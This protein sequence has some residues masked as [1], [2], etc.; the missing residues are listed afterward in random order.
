MSTELETQSTALVTQVRSIGKVVDAVTY[1]RK[2]EA[3]VGL[4]TLLKAIKAHYAPMKEAAD[5]AH[6]AVC[7]S[8]N[9]MVNPL[10]ALIDEQ[11]ADL[12]AW[13]RKQDQI[14]REEEL[15]VQT[16]ER[17]RAEDALLAEAAAAEAAGETAIAEAI[18]DLPVEA[19]RVVLPPSVPKVEGLRERPEY[20]SAEVYSLKMLVQAVAEGKVPMQ[21]IQAN[22][23][24]LNAQARSMKSTLAYPGVK[25]VSR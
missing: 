24:F 7:T 12:V 3:I 6:K 9:S 4:K 23:T 21:A 1:T 11:D 15:R 14:R 20:W 5:R 18:M 22:E 17:R 13:R 25:A 10:K 2:G 16:E 8:E 19:P